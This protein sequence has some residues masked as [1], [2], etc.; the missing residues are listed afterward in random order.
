LESTGGILLIW[1]AE[2]KEEQQPGKI[3]GYTVRIEES[4]GWA[5]LQGEPFESEFFS[6]E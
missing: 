1:E 4:K 3:L 5:A 6:A 2:S